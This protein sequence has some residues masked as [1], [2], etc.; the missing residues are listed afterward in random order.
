V[1]VLTPASDSGRAAAG[2]RHWRVKSSS[3][4]FLLLFCSAMLA[5]C[6]F[7]AIDDPTIL[8]DPIYWG[9]V[10][11]FA[12]VFPVAAFRPV[13]RLD[14]DVLTYRNLGRVRVI[15]RHQ[16]TDASAGYFGIFISEGHRGHICVVA[17]KTNVASVMNSET[18]ADEI[19]T[20]IARWAHVESGND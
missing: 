12:I 1:T 20:A 15:Q 8:R 3:R 17:Q 5:L 9:F 11:L 13:L 7:A 18:R 6:A 2:A 19:A 16:V 4:V 10:V 14:G